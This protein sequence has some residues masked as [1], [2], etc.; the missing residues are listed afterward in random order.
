MM[1]VVITL[2]DKERCKEGKEDE[3]GDGFRVVNF[4]IS[5]DVRRPDV[6]NLG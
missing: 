4:S 2:T 6:V 1:V 3:G 5:N